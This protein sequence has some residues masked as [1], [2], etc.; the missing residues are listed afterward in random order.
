V[1]GAEPALADG[2]CALAAGRWVEAR[3]AFER[4]LA[5]QE[6]PQA[7]F[8]LGMAL[9][10][11]GDNQGSVDRCA[12]AYALFRRSGEV[13]EAART[14]VWLAITYKAN[15]GNFAA[16][17]GWVARAE[18]LLAPLAPGPLHGWVWLA[19]G[20]RMVDLDV[21]ADLTTRAVEVARSAND[22]DLELVALSQLGLIQVGK[23]QAEAG[24]ALIDEAMAAALAGEG[25]ALD[26]VV[27]T[28]CDMLNACE[29]AADLERAAQWCAVADSFVDIYGCPFLYA[30]C[31]IYY[32]S[33]LTAKGR[34][35]DAERELTAGLRI[36][37]GAS[38]GLHARAALRLAGLRVRQG[39]LEE[40]DRLLAG[41]DGGDEAEQAL[42]AA[43]LALAR[44]DAAAAGRILEPRLR[45]L[46][47]H[48]RYLAS[49]LELL[50][51][52]R[53]ASGDLVGAGMAARRLAEA[54][55][56]AAGRPAATAATA[57]G[58]VAMATG[59]PEGAVDQ[60][61]TAVD[62]WA[63]LDLPYELARTRFDL[64]RALEAAEPDLATDHAR[65]ALVV[66]DRIG[67]GGD[68]D[69]V[70]AFLRS[71]G[72]TPR[73]G[74]RGTGTLT[75]REREV[76]RLLGEGLSNPEIAQRLHVTSKTASHHVSSILGK[77]GLRNRA[78]AAAH[79]VAPRT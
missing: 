62:L 19:R 3:V 7:S 66:L 11:L 27:Y 41:V 50:V 2:Y 65:R 57:L 36:T 12:A 9:W 72:V 52:A 49:A 23:G 64:A 37:D 17:N 16:A 53:L 56:A 70:A 43:A 58:R 45:E 31:R 48:R 51:D 59:D 68:A 39:R 28:C 63:D 35:A 77:L 60:L 18:R 42:A 44:G 1:S 4:A 38:P 29:L 32:G 71:R 5:V 26:T 34:W 6:T 14:A 21:A 74:V 47:E 24:F 8:G 46:R 30:E 61:R 54:A 67:A 22:V 69:R 25:D 15:F 10:W 76:L 73:T 40:A 33:V 13:V 79:A 20:Y 75:V 55:P 78:E